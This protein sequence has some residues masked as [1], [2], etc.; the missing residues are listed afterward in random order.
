MPH[1]AFS[2]R[3]YRHRRAR[4]VARR[5]WLALVGALVVVL[6]MQVGYWL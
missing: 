5:P 1:P 3:C 4:V 6:A 2:A